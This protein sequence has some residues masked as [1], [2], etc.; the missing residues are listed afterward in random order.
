[1]NI[2]PPEIVRHIAEFDQFA[3]Y[4]LYLFNDKFAEY[5]KTEAGIRQFIELFTEDFDFDIMDEL[6]FSKTHFKDIIGKCRILSFNNVKVAWYSQS[7]IYFKND[8]IHR[9]GDKPAVILP[10]GSFMWFKFD[11]PHRDGDKPA[12]MYWNGIHEWYQHG[13]CHRD[14]N[15]GPAV[16]DPTIGGLFYLEHGK[17]FRKCVDGCFI[18]LPTWYKYK[19]QL[20]LIYPNI[21]P[22]LYCFAEMDIATICGTKL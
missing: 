22:C 6:V 2:L 12:K 10:G 21:P 18:D 3:W 5:A 9:D 20:G 13:L 7:K 16:I 11:K 1:M 17:E 19:E 4:K 8:M 15:L 14:H